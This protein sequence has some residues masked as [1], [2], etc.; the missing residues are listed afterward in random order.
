MSITVRRPMIG[1]ALGGGGARGLAHIGVIKVLEK[2]NFPIGCIA[3]TSMGGFI[4]AGYASGMSAADLE[5]EA[6]RMA[7]VR[8]LLKLI[9]LAPPRRGLL[10]G[11]RVRAYLADVIGAELSF[12]DL[13]LPLALNAVDINSNQE[14]TM[15]EGPVLDAV[16]ATSA[17]PGV[18]PPV[19]MGGSML[20]D[21]GVLNNVPVSV[22]HQL[23]AEIVIA[24]DVSKHPGG[25]NQ[26]GSDERDSYPS[27][28]ENFFHAALVLQTSILK[29]SLRDTPPDI[30]IQPAISQ[31]IGIFTG[32]PRATEIIAAGERA[33][34]DTLPRLREILNNS[35]I[36]QRPNSGPEISVPASQTTLIANVSKS[37]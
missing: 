21:G 19:K 10:A 37:V 6:L 8:Q 13:R 35:A 2:E 29:A 25:S 34:Y 16:M 23:G 28:V 31:D 27:A 32:F 33:A 18:F 9:D 3:G 5:A 14:V 11:K 12:D 36:A 1:L 26:E 20:V 22:A 17:Y 15:R 4:G 7:S 30:L 24:V